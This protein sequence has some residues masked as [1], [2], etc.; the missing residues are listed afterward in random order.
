ML[1]AADFFAA[2]LRASRRVEYAEEYAERIRSRLE[3][4]AID[5]D[6]VPGGGASDG[7]LA[8]LEA[9]QRVDESRRE[10]SAYLDAATA[11][12]FDDDECAAG[13]LGEEPAYAVHLHYLE[14]LSFGGTARRLDCSKSWAIH[15]CAKCL[16]WL[17]AHR[18]RP[19]VDIP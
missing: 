3:C 5:Y 14:G 16:N 6:R 1:W 11:L 8:L 10:L 19:S 12:L 7:N 15:L 4:G 9:A 2:C 17:D 18:E 13:A